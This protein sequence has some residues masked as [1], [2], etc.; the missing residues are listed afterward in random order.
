MSEREEGEFGMDSGRN[1]G[2]FSEGG[3]MGFEPVE[4]VGLAIKES[5][6]EILK[7]FN[8]VHEPRVVRSLFASGLGAP[9]RLTPTPTPTPI[10][11]VSELV[12]GRGGEHWPPSGSTP[13]DAPPLSLLRWQSVC[14]VYFTTDMYILLHIKRS[15]E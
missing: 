11:S 5:A 9:C 12:Q 14:F 13:P 7:I 15:P 8:Q 10:L 3:T 4:N 6:Q 1:R 2:K